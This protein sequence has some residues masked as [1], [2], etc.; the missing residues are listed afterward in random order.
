MKVAIKVFAFI[1]VV[2]LLLKGLLWITTSSIQDDD[3]AKEVLSDGFYTLFHK[4]KTRSGGGAFTFKKDGTF[5]FRKAYNNDHVNRYE[6]TYQLGAYTKNG[7]K[8]EHRSVQLIWHT[9]GEFVRACGYSVGELTQDIS[10]GWTQ[11]KYCDNSYLN[12]KEK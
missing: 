10:D 6:G 9:Q 4:G 8:L 11:F 1:V 12:H 5:V 2:G 3:E 7:E